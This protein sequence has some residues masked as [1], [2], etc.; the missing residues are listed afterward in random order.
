MENHQ[1]IEADTQLKEVSVDALEALEALLSSSV[2]VGVHS[3]CNQG[4]HIMPEIT[5]LLLADKLS[6]VIPSASPA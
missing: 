6:C 5:R 1:T 4:P 2:F 3:E